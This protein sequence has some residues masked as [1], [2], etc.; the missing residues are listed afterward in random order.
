LRIVVALTAALV[1]SALVNIL[2]ALPDRVFTVTGLTCV[3]RDIL[4]GTSVGFT[5]FAL[6]AAAVVTFSVISI[7][8]LQ[9]RRVQNRL[10]AGICRTRRQ[11]AEVI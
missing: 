2:T 4:K 10:V 7:K 11:S 6:P 5:C 8:L 1:I 3:N 9:S